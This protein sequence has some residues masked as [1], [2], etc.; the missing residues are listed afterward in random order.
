MFKSTIKHTFSNATE[1]QI[2]SSDQALYD[3]GKQFFDSRKAYLNIFY[4]NVSYH[5]LA[6]DNI[7]SLPSL[8]FKL[9]LLL[10]SSLNLIPLFLFGFFKKDKSKGALKV[11]Q[12]AECAALLNYCKATQIKTVYYFSLFEPDSNIC[13]FLL[14][15]AGIET[16]LVTSEVPLRFGNTKMIGT[17]I[18]FCFGYQLEEYEYYKK[19][20]LAER[21][22][23]L[24][25]ETVNETA[26]YY[27]KNNKF[28]TP[29]NSI[30]FISSGMWLRKQIGDADSGLNELENE[31]KILAWLLEFVSN[32]A[33]KSLIIFLHPLEKNK[34]YFNDTLKHYK[35]LYKNLE[36]NFAP[37]NTSSAMSFNNTDV[38]VALYSTLIY[39]RIFMGFKSIITPLQIDNFPLKDSSLQKSSAKSKDEL[40]Q[41]L[42]DFLQFTNEEYIQRIGFE[43]H[44]YKNFKQL[45]AT[46]IN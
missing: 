13:S 16:C 20:I 3:S 26:K 42:E 37:L 10:V 8:P 11:T 28:E 30:G 21:V 36:P 22:K 14:N 5:N 23:L 31:G 35:T 17:E 7:L 18:N 44:Y 33:T 41:K 9:T 38:A 40:F 6:K 2:T 27:I 39:E 29:K 24:I 25:P 46:N 15:R 34:K 1:Q 43:S 32:D 4:P 19:D 45:N 12:S